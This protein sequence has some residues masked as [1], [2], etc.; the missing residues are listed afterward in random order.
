MTTQVRK[1]GVHIIPA[2]LQRAF[3]ASAAAAVIVSSVLSPARSDTTSAQAAAAD[4]S[5]PDTAEVP[6]V[7]LAGHGADLWWA[8]Y[9]P[10]G[11]RAVT[12]SSD[13]T[14]RVWDTATGE[15]VLTLAGHDEAVRVAI[16]SPNGEL[17]GERVSN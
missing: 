16:F 3:A 13:K 5:A 14:A 12:A 10:D 6:S 11:K 8:D 2:R 15:T 7:T 4:P 1:A 17:P 9:S